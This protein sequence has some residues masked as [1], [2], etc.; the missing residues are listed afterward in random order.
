MFQV[1]D[2]QKE[3]VDSLE[4]KEVNINQKPTKNTIRKTF[5][6]IQGSTTSFQDSKTPTQCLKGKNLILYTAITMMIQINIIK[7]MVSAEILMDNS[8]RYEDKMS[9]KINKIKKVKMKII[10]RYNN[11][12]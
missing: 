7:L 8:H 10:E 4:D 11:K 2:K 1:L 5:S 6:K 3:E 9:I 12:N